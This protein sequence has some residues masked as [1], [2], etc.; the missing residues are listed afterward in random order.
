MCIVDD[1]CIRLHI[2][3][4]FKMCIFLYLSLFAF[5]LFIWL[6]LHIF[7]GLLVHDHFD[8]TVWS[9]YVIISFCVWIQLSVMLRLEFNH[10]N[11]SEE[12]PVCQGD[13]YVFLL[14]ET[15]SDMQHSH[16]N[17][18]AESCRTVDTKQ[19]HKSMHAHKHTHT[20][21]TGDNQTCTYTKTKRHIHTVMHSVCT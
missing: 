10:V 7:P 2:V 15:Q 4:Y 9:S 8:H 5:S 12:Q 11:Q 16:G 21:T 1:G 3:I 14:P 17:E 20:H 13:W 18:T 19:R 6:Y